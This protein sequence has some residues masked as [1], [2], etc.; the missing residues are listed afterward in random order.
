MVRALNILGAIS[1]V[2]WVAGAVVITAV[3]VTT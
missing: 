3:M 2:L 1:A